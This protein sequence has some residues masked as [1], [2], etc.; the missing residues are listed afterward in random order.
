ME[1]YCWKTWKNMQI[2]SRSIEYT[3][4]YDYG[5][6]AP[7]SILKAASGTK[8]SKDVRKGAIEPMKWKGN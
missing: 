1:K 2:R 3:Q 5:N 7:M 4:L 6:R 8:I